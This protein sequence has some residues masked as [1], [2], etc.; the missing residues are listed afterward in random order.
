MFS[1]V[2]K[3]GLVTITGPQG[4]IQYDTQRCNHCAGHFTVSSGN[5]D[6]PLP[7]I[8]MCRVCMEFICPECY[9]KHAMQGCVTM[10]QRIDEAYERA[11]TRETYTQ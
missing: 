9:G 11:R 6:V 7:E 2:A 10:R 5:P 4:T 3:A 8:N 1:R